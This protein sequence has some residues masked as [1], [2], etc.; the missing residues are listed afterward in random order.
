MHLTKEQKEVL[1]PINVIVF[2]L[3]V[4]VIIALIITTFFI[5]KGSEVHKLLDDI[6]HGVCV[7]FFIDFLHRFFHAKSKK[8]YMRW[9]WIDLISSI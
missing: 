9:G 4:Y 7:I 6:D 3:S 5:P 1:H 2:F 8:Q